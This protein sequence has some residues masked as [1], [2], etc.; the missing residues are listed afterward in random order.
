[1]RKGVFAVVCCLL[2]C[3]AGCAEH[4][5]AYDPATCLEPRICA[6]GKT[7]GEPL[8]HELL[9]ATCTSAQICSRCGLT[10]G[11]A[12]GH[13]FSEATCTAARTCSRCQTTQGEAL[14]HDYSEASCTEGQTCKRCAEV[15]GSALGHDYANDFCT[16]CGAQD[17]E[18]VPVPL[19]LLPEIDATYECRYYDRVLTDNF[20]K[21]YVGYHFF[22]E[23]GDNP[24]TVIYYLEGKYKSFSCDVLTL[25]KSKVS[26]AI[27]VDDQ[28]VFQSERFNKTAGTIHVDLNI[29]GGQ[30][31]KISSWDHEYSWNDTVYVVNAQLRK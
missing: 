19:N 26:F 13:S 5:H 6:C 9:P 23:Q 30:Q 17:P 20:G 1:M 22:Q 11:E 18:S 25:N 2:V 16:R 12:L 3:F 31:L 4:A 14:G 21:D 7:K 29:T 28:I 8:G 27:Y 15:V 24:G 10:N